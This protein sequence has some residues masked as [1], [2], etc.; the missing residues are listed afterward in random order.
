VSPKTRTSTKEISLWLG[1]MIFLPLDLDVD[2]ILG[3]DLR[4]E[5]HNISALGTAL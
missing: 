3:A 2:R 5:I 1:V 4:Q